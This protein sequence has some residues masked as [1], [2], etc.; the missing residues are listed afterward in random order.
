LFHV[1]C[2]LIDGIGDRSLTDISQALH[3]QP[4]F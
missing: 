3:L 4:E 2:R 1:F